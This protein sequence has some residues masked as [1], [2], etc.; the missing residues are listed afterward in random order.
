M[1]LTGPTVDMTGKVSDLA[2]RLGDLETGQDTVMALLGNILKNQQDA[3]K[4]PQNDIAGNATAPPARLTP[5]EPTIRPTATSTGPDVAALL[6]AAAG[7]E[8]TPAILPIC[9]RDA[10]DPIVNK[11]VQ[12]LLNSAQKISALKGRPSYVH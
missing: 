11:Q 3:A 8:D 2:T 9:Y 12:T 10:V 7:R 1:D 5:P 6:A 4:P